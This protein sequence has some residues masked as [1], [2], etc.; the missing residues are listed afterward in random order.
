MTVWQQHSCN[1]SFQTFFCSE[2]VAGPY[3]DGRS[4]VLV[5]SHVEYIRVE[6]QREFQSTNMRYSKPTPSA[7]PCSQSATA[8]IVPV[9]A[10]CD[11][12]VCTVVKLCLR[13][14]DVCRFNAHIAGYLSKSSDGRIGSRYKLGVS[15]RIYVVLYR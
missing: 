3:V 9:S 5:D 15:R 4:G 2:A 11:Q 7:E 10:I 8:A 12:V 14:V 1:E 6:R 13:P